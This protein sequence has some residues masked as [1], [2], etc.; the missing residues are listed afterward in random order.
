[1]KKLMFLFM[2]IL[3]VGC[4][5]TTPVLSQFNPPAWIQGEWSSA[6]GSNDFVFS[7]ADVVQKAAGT[8]LDL[9][10][11]Y[12]TAKVTESVSNTVY[13]FHVVSPGVDATYSFTSASDGWVTYVL[14]ANG[15]TCAPWA[16]TKIR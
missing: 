12:K 5:P 8:S 1:M 3:I 6:D 9:A 11:S 10:V 2:S 4:A 15:I 14:S 13:S 16:L 7:K